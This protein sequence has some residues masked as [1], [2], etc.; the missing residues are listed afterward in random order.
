MFIVSCYATATIAL[1][2]IL[3]FGVEKQ[4]N[5]PRSGVRVGLVFASLVGGSIVGAGS[6]IFHR[7]A[8]VIIAPLAGFCAYRFC[9]AALQRPPM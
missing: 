3:H 7:G 6:V 8:K 1:V 4:V 2:L 5:P 9:A